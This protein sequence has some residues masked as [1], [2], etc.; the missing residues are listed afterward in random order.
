MVLRES[1]DSAFPPYTTIFPP[2]LEEPF[3]TL[4]SSRLAF[5]ASIEISPREYFANRSLKALFEIPILEAHSDAV[6]DTP[7]IENLRYNL[8]DFP[9]IP[10][11][12]SGRPASLHALFRASTHS[13]SGRSTPPMT[14]TIALASSFI[15][16][17]Q[18][19][20]ACIVRLVRSCRV[21]ISSRTGLCFRLSCTA[22]R[23][24]GRAAPQPSCSR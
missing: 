11:Q 6:I 15:P 17:P 13:P 1:R 3:L 22:S 8:P 9:K 4:L 5:M 21:R 18:A 12:T 16:T 20:S 10:T 23:I 2:I 24:R 7:P 14:T 19:P